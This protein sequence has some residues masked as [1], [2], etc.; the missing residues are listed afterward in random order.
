MDMS[1]ENDMLVKMF[2]KKDEIIESAKVIFDMSKLL[3]KLKDIDRIIDDVPIHYEEYFNNNEMTAML[4]SCPT[5]SEKSEVEIYWL[6]EPG[7][8]RIDSEKYTVREFYY[9]LTWD[10]VIDIGCQKLV[11]EIKNEQD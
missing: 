11:E 1:K 3:D 9:D 7:K 6:F 8:F 4:L 2:E 10:E 5:C